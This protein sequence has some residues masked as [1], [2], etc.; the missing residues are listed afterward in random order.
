MLG[1][2]HSHTRALPF[3]WA[4]RSLALVFA[5]WLFIVPQVMSTST[6][7][8]LCEEAGSTPLPLIEEEEV[9]HASTPPPGGLKG[10]GL[11]GMH[12][13]ILPEGPDRP[14]QSLH[15]EVPHLPPWC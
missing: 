7:I 1:S 2:S 4:L 8:D 10:T 6:V 5:L 9:K 11:D 13:I 3:G 14:Q 12:N 15:G